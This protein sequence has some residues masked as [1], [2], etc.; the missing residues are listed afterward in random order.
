MVMV[1]ISSVRKTAEYVELDIRERGKEM[2]KTKKKKLSIEYTVL[3]LRATKF[4][5]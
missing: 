5:H 1:Y 4:I 3:V 2:T